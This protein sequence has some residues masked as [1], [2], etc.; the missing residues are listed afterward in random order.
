MLETFSTDRWCSSQHIRTKAPVLRAATSVT[1]RDTQVPSRAWLL[2]SCCGSCCDDVLRFH[3]AFI[4][5]SSSSPHDVSYQ[6][7]PPTWTD[8]RSIALSS[9]VDRQ[10]SVTCW[11]RLR[12]SRLIGIPMPLTLVT[13][14]LW[15]TVGL[16]ALLPSL[17]SLFRRKIPRARVIG[18]SHLYGVCTNR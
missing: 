17:L 8:A 13:A 11:S 3:V 4:H 9:P 12:P 5:D 2:G 6:A 14:G 16:F 7:R 10:S 1:I 18:L 15:C